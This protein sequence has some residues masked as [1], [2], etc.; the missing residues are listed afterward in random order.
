MYTK[1]LMVTVAATAM[2]IVTSAA[3]AKTSA[4]AGFRIFN[5]N[6][7]NTWSTD[8]TPCTGVTFPQSV[9]PK[10]NAVISADSNMMPTYPFVCSTIY[11][12]GQN[13]QCLV[14]VVNNKEGLSVQTDAL[15]GSQDCGAFAENTMVNL[16]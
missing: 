14:A 3:A 9:A 11:S 10:A 4:V 12:D 16:N 7:Q 5:T 8:T 2:L 15:S 1:K 13:K 6:T